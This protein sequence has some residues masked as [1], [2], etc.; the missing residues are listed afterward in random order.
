M[1]KLTVLVLILALL[2]LT[3]C[4]S[5]APKAG[6]DM[7]NKNTKGSTRTLINRANTFFF[8]C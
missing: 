8:M 7:P 2:A 3:G 5:A 6:K 1:K 4:S